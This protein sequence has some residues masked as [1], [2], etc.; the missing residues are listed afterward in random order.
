MRKIAILPI[1]AVSL[2]LPGPASADG[3]V[4]FVSIGFSG[5]SDESFL[6]P[7][8]HTL[9]TLNSVEVTITG[10]MFTTA[11]TLPL[12]GSEGPIPTP[13]SVSA[14]LNFFGISDGS[15]FKF[16]QPATFQFN[17]IS[18]GA[19]GPQQLETFFSLGFKLDSFTDILGQAPLGSVGPTVPPILAIGTLASFTDTFSPIMSVFMENTPGSLPSSQASFTSSFVLGDISVEYD[20]TPAPAPVPEPG[21]LLLLSTVAGI[22][23]GVRGRRFTGRR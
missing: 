10:K 7:F 22:A 9:G 6:K 13:F 18:S 15:F 2:I 19:G 17:G 23:A 11:Q 20:Y 4:Q 8:D 1:L 16:F 12:S 21:T 5:S 3:L 14:D